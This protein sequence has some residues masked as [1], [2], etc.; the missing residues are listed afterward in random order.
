[1]KKPGRNELCPC[2]SGKKYKKCCLDN[3]A[4]AGTFIYTDLDMLSNKVNELIK[5]GRLAEA[6]DT[7]RILMKKYPDQIDGLHRYAEVYEAMGE[8]QKA[9]KYYRKAANFAQQSGGFGQE[10]IDLFLR[11]AQLLAGTS[12]E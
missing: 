12:E 5:D 11:Q 7:C 10:T 3:P 9:A 8:K 1:M 6:E 2:G 4:M